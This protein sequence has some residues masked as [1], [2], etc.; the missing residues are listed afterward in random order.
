MSAQLCQG[1]HSTPMRTSDRESHFDSSLCT[2][3][4]QVDKYLT[5]SR[6]PI[7]YNSASLQYHQLNHVVPE[8]RDSRSSCF[9][10]NAIPFRLMLQTPIYGIVNNSPKKDPISMMS[11]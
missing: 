1:S 6:G 4:S 7:V 5:C 11:L 9:P 3:M 2:R 10:P 8:A